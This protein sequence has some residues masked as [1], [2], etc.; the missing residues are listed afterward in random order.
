MKYIHA[1]EDESHVQCKTFT[2]SSPTKMCGVLYTHTYI[3]TCY[4]GQK[5]ESE[6]LCLMTVT[7]PQYQYYLV[8]THVSIRVSENSRITFCIMLFSDTGYTQD[9]I[10][11]IW[12][13]HHFKMK[14]YQY[15]Q[16]FKNSVPFTQYQCPLNSNLLHLGHNPQA[17]LHFLPPSWTIR[18][19]GYMAVMRLE[20]T[21]YELGLLQY[22]YYIAVTADGSE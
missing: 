15:F 6:T 7:L 9:S 22:H 2:D 19:P 14:D 10:L 11:S 12:F 4:N 17:P 8:H 1:R 5:G 20:H 18:G 21:D 3:C 16:Q 13:Q